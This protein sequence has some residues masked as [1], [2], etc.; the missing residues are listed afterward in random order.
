MYYLLE[1]TTYN[2]GSPVGKGVY[3]YDSPDSALA[4]FHQKLAGAINNATYASE[5]CMIIVGNGGVMRQEFWERPV[6]EPQ[7]E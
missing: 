5:L 2:N 1:I 7:P 3:S 4:A 6:E